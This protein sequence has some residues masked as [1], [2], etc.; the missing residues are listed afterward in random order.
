MT[1]NSDV[2][3]VIPAFN[4]EAFI[5]EAIDSALAQDGA[6]VEVL[7]IDDGSTDRTADVVRGYGGRVRLLRTAEARSGAGAA[8]NVGLRHAAAPLIAFLDGDDVWLPGKLARQ[9]WLLD[10]R[11]EVGLVCARG[12]F[13][14]PED[15]A[16]GVPPVEPWAP[17]EAIPLDV[18]GWAYHRLLL[19]PAWVWT[20]TVVLR[21]ELVE[22]VG[23]FDESLRLGQ[24][25]DYWLRASR[26]T[27]IQRIAQPLALYR[28]HAD[29]STRTAPRQRNYELEIV[30]RALARW[31]PVGPDG[32]EIPP[33]DLRRRMGKLNFRMG[34]IHY[35]HGSP[36]IAFRS[37]C[38]AVAYT[39]SAWKV[40]AYVAASSMHAVLRLRSRGGAA[41]GEA[42]TARSGPAR[43]HGRS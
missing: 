10:E 27:R 18:D 30:E 37:F 3:V 21:R 16:G 23:G 34:Y 24:D 11:P 41:G 36:S 15:G 13:W 17:G 40:W 25:Y 29:N 7:V 14:Y 4:C 35:W 12:V 20:T 9:K 42:L 22:R 6:R 26:E 39:P 33:A 43:R 19:R 8:R 28:Q 38:R 31:G 1:A 32:L 5:G 2:S